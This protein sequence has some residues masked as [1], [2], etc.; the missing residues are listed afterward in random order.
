MRVGGRGLTAVEVWRSR[1]SD[2]VR[3]SAVMGSVPL[4]RMCDSRRR[5]SKM[6]PARRNCHQGLMCA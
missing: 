4:S 2:S 1:M 6:L 3:G 5:L